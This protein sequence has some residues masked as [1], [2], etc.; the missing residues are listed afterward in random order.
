MSEPIKK[1][2]PASATD[3]SPEV[4]FALVLSRMIESVEKDPALLRGTVYEL[5]RVKLLEQFGREDVTEV[6]R[7]VKALETAIQGVEAFTQHEKTVR[8][9]I[10]SSP[11]P[12]KLTNSPKE[13][14]A[15]D[16]NARPPP[17]LNA[18]VPAQVAA[19]AL[20]PPR[21]KARVGEPSAAEI[22]KGRLRPDA[23]AFVA[24]LVTVF[25]LA[26]LAGFAA[27]S[28][29]RLRSFV[30]IVRTAAE[31][32]AWVSP[33]VNPTS[34]PPVAA[35]VK[36]PDP[37]AAQAAPGP[38]P[39]VPS[40]LLPTT[41]GIYAL[42]DSQLQEL[43][44]LPG[45]VPD[46]RVAVSAAINTPSETTIPSGDAKFIVF[47]RDAATNAPDH[48]EVRVVA[49]VTRA[50]GV[51]SAGKVNVSQTQETWVIRNVSF[52][53]KIGPVKDHP[54]MF[55]VQ[56]EADNFFLPAGRYALVL[57]GQGFD[58]TVVGPVTDARQCLERVDAVNGAFYSPC[59][60]K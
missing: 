50:M 60:G 30:E 13:L 24:R 26:G 40:P 21:Q 11:D 12:K 56:P 49:R 5:A 45:K 8:P 3:H 54:E 20:Q 51:D 28:W 37:E 42:S 41:F 1:P 17:W 18:P 46:P 52:P 6:N 14:I 43:K 33:K 29:P 59:S 57:K 58:F 53:Y 35:A 44:P 32:P 34:S 36:A 19:L 16:A 22:L 27:M 2:E 31:S 10:P 23:F 9:L 7:L 55:Q 47:R 4:N 25:C 15:P 48:A 38:S 39:L